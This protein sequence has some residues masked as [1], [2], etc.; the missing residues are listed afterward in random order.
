MVSPD[1]AQPPF[2]MALDIGS[3]SIR[4][5]LFDR[6][7]QFVEGMSASHRHRLRHQVPGA[8]ELVPQELVEAVFHCIDEVLNAADRL[9]DQIGAVAST[10][11]VTNVMGI[12]EDG[13]PLTPLYTYAD[14]RAQAAASRLQSSLDE[15]DVIHRTGCRFHTSYLPARFLWLKNHRPDLFGNVHRWLSFG[16]YLYL[17]LFG[18]AEVTYS[19]ASWTG[20]LNRHKLAWDD[21]VL[22]QLPIDQAHLS[23]LCDFDDPQYG[24]QKHFTQRWPPLKDIPWYPTIGD[25]AAANI[26]SM[27]LSPKR[28]ALTVGTSSAMRITLRQKGP[29]IPEGLWCYQVTRDLSLIGGALNEGGNLY[30]WLT[31]LFEFNDLRM[32][33]E[34]IAKMT[35]DSHQL[36]FLPFL[37]GERSP[38]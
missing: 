13:Q 23:R 31:N 32:I 30:E 15:Q 38:G 8:A 28:V 25:G 14:T 4:V 11:L 7:G 19:V 29:P 22:S 1:Q 2:V 17:K 3:S 37:T 16:E 5:S 24:L 20:L 21:E 36:T 10:T 34:S 12:S 18:R 6:L 33:D 9:N 26:G 35:P 27:C